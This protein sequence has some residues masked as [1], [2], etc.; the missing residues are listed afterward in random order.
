MGENKCCSHFREIK[1]K[2]EASVRFRL[3][4]GASI[5]SRLFKP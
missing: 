5:E 1:I 4:G 2:F 3:H